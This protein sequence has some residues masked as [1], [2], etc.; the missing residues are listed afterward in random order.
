[1][2]TKNAALL[3]VETLG[4]YERGKQK[5]IIIPHFTNLNILLQFLPFFSPN[6]CMFLCVHKTQILSYYNISKI[7]MSLR[8]LAT[9]SFIFVLSLKKNFWAS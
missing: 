8:L 2:Y 4:K 9:F 1:M 5:L 3:P 6:I 7:V